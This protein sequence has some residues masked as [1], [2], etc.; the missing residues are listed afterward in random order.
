MM[1][2]VGE[3]L[4]CATRAPA[5][6]RWVAGPRAWSVQRGRSQAS[7]STRRKCLG[8]ASR[9][10]VPNYNRQ[11]GLSTMRSRCFGPEVD[12]PNHRLSVAPASAHS[13]RAGRGPAPGTGETTML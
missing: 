6:P 8:D 4:K 10:S 13:I 1:V 5:R 2:Q 12:D 3:Q 11:V 7:R 9:P